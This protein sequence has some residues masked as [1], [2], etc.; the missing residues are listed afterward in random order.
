[1]DVAQFRP[2]GPYTGPAGHP[3]VAG[4]TL[5]ELLV[6]LAVL[7]L[8]LTLGVPAYSGFA[9][10]NRVAAQ[11]NALAADLSFARSEAIKR[12]SPVMVCLSPDGIKCGSGNAWDQGWI[13]F[14]DVDGDRTRAP[15]EPLLR[16]QGPFSGGTRLRYAGYPT[17]RYVVYLPT[18]ITD[19]TNGTFTFCPRDSAYARALILAK[20]GRVRSSRTML[21]GNPINCN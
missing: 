18:G 13:V 20:T 7:S 19:H 9:T 5:Q 16:V 15:N 10:T 6:T 8:C 21:N 14:P 2:V 17:D 1:M 4:Y 12:R 11:H 3:F